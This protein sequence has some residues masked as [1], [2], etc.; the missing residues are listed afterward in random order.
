M[1]E[2]FSNRFLLFEDRKG[3]LKKAKIFNRILDSNLRRFL[4][5][6]GAIK[7]KRKLTFFLD[8]LKSYFK[9][10]NFLYD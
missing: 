2:I 6:L 5:F 10:F 7:T 8:K 9:G 4:R 1:N 3:L